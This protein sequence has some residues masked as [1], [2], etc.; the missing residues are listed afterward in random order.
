MANGAKMRIAVVTVG[1]SDFSI[2]RPLCTRLHND[3]AFEFGLWVGGAHFD[4]QSGETIN[5]VRDTGLPIWAEI[6]SAHFAKTPLGTVLGMAD[7]MAGFG[8]VADNTPRPDMVLVL[9]DR[10]EAIAAGLAMVP[11]NIP[12]GHISGGSVTEG[13]I[14]DVFRHCLSKIAAVHFC[15]IPEF[16][17]RIHQLGEDPRTI[18]AV[19]ALGLDG[20]AENTPHS[21]EDFTTHFGFGSELNPGFVLATLHPETRAPEMTQAMALNMITVLENTGYPVIYTY[22][23]A[24]PFS[25]KIIDAIEAAAQRNRNHH[26]V[27]NFGAT[28]FYTALS[29]AGLVV[30]NSSSGIIEAASFRLPVVDIG[31]RQKGRYHGPN[32]IRSGIDLNEIATAVAQAESPAMS[33]RIAGL[34][35]PYGDGQTAKRIVAVLKKYYMN[36]EK[37]VKSFCAFDP[38]YT[39]EFL[40][41]SCD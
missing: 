14:D 39:G 30:G 24:D 5:A 31:D 36:E 25:D 20:I 22:P 27:K 28:W 35:N 32:V 29:L 26:V 19:G 23:N 1:R 17:R 41:I 2:L 6:K 37:T 21:F 40:E 38:N 8:R 4:P 34:I 15:E 12:V 10:Y 7:Q 13:A 16:A 9:G 33:A 11:F 3:T 18:F